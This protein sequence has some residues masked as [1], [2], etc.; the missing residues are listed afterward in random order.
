MPP[1][2][3]PPS[4][5][6]PPAPLLQPACS[7]QGQC[8]KLSWTPL[9][10][11][12]NIAKW[13]ASYCAHTATD[14]G[15]CDPNAFG[16][17]TCEV[18]DAT[19]SYSYPYENHCCTN[20]GTPDN[21]TWI[22]RPELS[23]LDGGAVINGSKTSIERVDYQVIA[24]CDCAAY[25]ELLKRT[26]GEEKRRLCT[27]NPNS[28]AC[29][30]RDFVFSILTDKQAYIVAGCFTALPALVLLFLTCAG[31]IPLPVA[32]TFLF[33]AGDMFTDILY[34]TSN[35]F[36]SYGLLVASIVLI[37]GPIVPYALVIVL[38]SLLT[39]G[40]WGGGELW[41]VAREQAWMALS[42]QIPEFFDKA[43]D[44]AMQETQRLGRSIS[45]MAEQSS[46]SCVAGMVYTVMI[47]FFWLPYAVGA[48]ALVVA[49]ALAMGGFVLLCYVVSWFCLFVVGGAL[50]CRAEML[51]MPSVTQILTGLRFRETD[52]SSLSATLYHTRV[53]AG[54]FLQSIPTI[55]VQCLNNTGLQKSGFDGAWSTL[56][57]CSIIISGLAAL[58]S[59]W[60]CGRECCR[61]GTEFEEWQLPKFDGPPHAT[62]GAGR[63]SMQ[64]L[65]AAP[66]AL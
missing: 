48:P 15:S 6:A 60:Q 10:S 13:G 56:N 9:E 55:A 52:N 40:L 54:L 43:W 34:I 25:G 32:L 42:I 11:N 39:I 5:W 3:V 24:H 17:Y 47:L 49:V 53:L 1:G 51:T 14:W 22:V 29:V 4:Q 31:G 46:N 44:G 58:F 62:F 57:V 28:G 66:V 64:A 27:C 16:R 50:L 37:I 65:S 23:Y 35:A 19:C 41:G 20:V 26:A 33:A 8:T 21:P 38:P 18:S 61:H 30:P 36:T 7:C 59:I 45:D 63:L 2:F 12:G